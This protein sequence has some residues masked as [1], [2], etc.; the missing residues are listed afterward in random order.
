[1]NLNILLRYTEDMWTTLVTPTIHGWRQRPSTSM[2]MMALGWELS[3]YMQVIY[4]KTA[5][6][7]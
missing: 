7:A 5:D 1:M 6:F 4:L 2:M 3:S